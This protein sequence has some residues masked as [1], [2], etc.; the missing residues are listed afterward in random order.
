M[1]G[2]QIEKFNL[3][4]ALKFI[5]IVIV[6]SHGEVK[7]VQSIWQELLVLVSRNWICIDL[8]SVL[9]V[10]SDK[11]TPYVAILIVKNF[12]RLGTGILYR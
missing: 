11:S 3:P 7:V 4:L 10:A 1:D 8:H 2:S 5:D 6:T 9:F 12:K